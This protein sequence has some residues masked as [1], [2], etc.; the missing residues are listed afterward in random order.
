MWTRLASPATLRLYR[1]GQ[2]SRV[3]EGENLAQIDER[4]SDPSQR[5]FKAAALGLLQRSNPLDLVLRL[6]LVVSLA[7]AILFL[8]ITLNNPL[9]DEHGFR[10]TQTAINVHYI[11]AEG[12]IVDYQTPTLG[13]PW[14]LPFE[15]PV[16]QLLVAGFVAA[17]GLDI[18]PAG[19]IVSFL[20]L[21][22]TI[23]L[24]SL[25]LRLIF[26]GDRHVGLLFAV[27][28]LASPLYLFWGRTV[29]VET[30]ATFFGAAWLYL[31]ILATQRRSILL[32]LM[33]IPLCIMASLAKGTTWPA[34]VLAYG[35]Y[36]LSE[37]Y[38]HRHID[39]AQTIVVGIGVALAL[40][41]GLVWTEYAW[42]VRAQGDLGRSLE[43]SGWIY[44][45]WSD[46][47][48]A[49]LWG[50]IL[51]DRMLPNILGLAWLVI[52]VAG[53]HLVFGG[54]YFVAAWACVILFAVPIAIFSN[55]QLYHDYYQVSNGL[56]LTAFAAI[57]VAGLIA[58]ERERTAIVVL[59]IVLAGQAVRIA[60]VQWPS[61]TRDTT[62]S[63]TLLAAKYVRKSTDPKSA[64]VLIGPEGT[65]EVHYYAQRKGL[66]TPSWVS[67]EEL[68]RSFK[69]PT[70]KTEGRPI[71][72]VVRCTGGNV[73]GRRDLK[74][75][76]EPFFLSAKARALTNG[77][78]ETFGTCTVYVLPAPA[79]P[80]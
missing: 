50:G 44:G 20:F 37:V 72:A 48:G 53:T 55:V 80:E 66:V 64:L 8:A 74:P 29:L 18:D 61:A 22:G 67:K 11:L 3:N 28:M 41:I 9:L 15:A 56:F 34:F 32:G 52:I 68:E 78:V 6:L 46:R 77:H 30:C 17:T 70:V 43:I 10:Q 35:L 31:A 14:A 54:R 4:V 39:I 27:L 62:Q 24:G 58:R 63:P 12:S 65:P 71:G 23:A 7:F 75:V 60:T 36:W 16:Y 21:L 26:P 51:P 19:R 1:D 79:K 73:D 76:W 42:S 47:F 57:T 38:R 45:T 13:T 59:A 69:D 25:T 5:G 33:A 40:T 2:A 49:R